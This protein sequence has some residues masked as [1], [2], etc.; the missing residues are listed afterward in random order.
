[1]RIYKYR[2]VG[3]TWKAAGYVKAVAYDY[4]G[5]T[6]YKVSMRLS[7]KGSWRLRAY[8]PADTGHLR[9]WSSKFDYV[10]VK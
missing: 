5:Y 4:K 9:M 3:K 6:R 7:T 1:M 10:T 8:A 2:K